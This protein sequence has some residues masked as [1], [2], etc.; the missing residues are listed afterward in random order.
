LNGKQWESLFEG[1]SQRKQAKD[2]RTE[3]LRELASWYDEQTQLVMTLVREVI[4]ER[5]AAFEER[6]GVHIDVQWPSHPPINVGPDG[7]FMSF[8]CLRIPERE[9]HL[10][11]HRVGHGPPMIHFV[12]VRDRME[13][14]R[15]RLIGRSGCR[16]ERREGGGFLL[17]GVQDGQNESTTL[18]VDDLAYRA[19]ALLLGEL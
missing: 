13:A 14:R 2:A 1:F 16:I 5:A 12:V 7:P 9:V 3:S 17:Q 6:A 8:M 4:S 10:Y 19:F 11:S 15:E 18:S